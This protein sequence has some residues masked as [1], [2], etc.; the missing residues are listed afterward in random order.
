M[1]RELLE[2]DPERMALLA[3]EVFQVQFIELMKLTRQLFPKK[4]AHLM[5][6]SVIG[7]VCYYL[8]MQPLRQYLPGYQAEHEQPRIIAGHI[9]HLL[10]AQTENI[11]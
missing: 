8:E 3:R 1:Q 2:A 11:R 7:L 9:C 6:V 10:M 4:D 5:A